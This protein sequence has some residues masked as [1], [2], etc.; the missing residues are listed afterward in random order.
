MKIYDTF[1]A[2]LMLASISLRNAS[3]VVH[4]IWRESSMYSIYKY[5]VWVHKVFVSHES[6]NMRNR[7]V[8]E[9]YSS[10]HCIS[11]KLGSVRSL[12]C[13]WQLYEWKVL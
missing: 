3:L 2:T 9:V 8:K 1:K 5:F 7:V 10:F 12:L 13:E 6:P 11:F 4:R